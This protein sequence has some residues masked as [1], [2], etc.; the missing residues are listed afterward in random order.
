MVDIVGGIDGANGG[1]ADVWR[2]RLVE[3]RRSI[4]GQNGVGEG[5]GVG[6]GRLKDVDLKGKSDVG[7]GAGVGTGTVHDSD[8]S[9]RDGTKFLVGA[10]PTA[11]TGIGSVGSKPAGVDVGSGAGRFGP[12]GGMAPSRDEGIDIVTGIDA[13]HEVDQGHGDGVAGGGV[14]GSREGVGD[15]FGGRKG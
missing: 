12:S 8:G 6:I 2:F 1:D 3:E 14:G 10:V 11:D 4:V 9:G 15:V 5:A 7:G 13:L